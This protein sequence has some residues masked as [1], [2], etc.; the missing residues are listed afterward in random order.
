M[1]PRQERGLDIATNARI[2]RKGSR[3]FVPAENGA[4]RYTVTLH[5][6]SPHCTCPDHETTG[7]ECKHIYA[8]QWALRWKREDLRNIERVD[9]DDGRGERKTYPQNWRAYNA[10]QTGE[11][12][13][14]LDL[15]F[16]LC[17]G[18]SEPVRPK[19]GCSNVDR[20]PGPR[21][22][23][24]C[25]HQARCLLATHSRQRWSRRLLYDPQACST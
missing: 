1:D 5:S 10:A 13:M 6:A 8:V 12:D 24:C 19:T 3:W 11:K 9:R 16:D 15:L 18:V 2:T 17:S 22:S 25:P 20:L 21:R 23:R 14:F 7:R 4:G